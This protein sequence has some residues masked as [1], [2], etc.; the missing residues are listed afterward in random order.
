MGCV[1]EE[2]FRCVGFGGNGGRCL[3]AV[4]VR[5]GV[6]CEGGRDVGMVALVHDVIAA[7]PSVLDT[8]ISGYEVAL[9]SLPPLYELGGRR[10]WWFHSK[11]QGEKIWSRC[12]TYGACGP[13]YEGA[14]TAL[15]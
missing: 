13:R 12:W 8:I 11:I 1:Y 5:A 9:R 15:S 2:V 14:M 6:A 7:L 3:G 10:P 4:V